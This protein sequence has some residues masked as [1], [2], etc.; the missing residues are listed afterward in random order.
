MVPP[1]DALELIKFQITM[2]QYQ[3]SIVSL[4]LLLLPVIGFSQSH[5]SKSN[6]S[7][8][9][10]NTSPSAASVISFHK[11]T[12]SFADIIVSSNRVDH[13]SAMA[14]SSLNKQQIEQ[15]NLGQD[16]PYLL[17]QQPSVVTTSD[18]GTGVGYTGIRIRGSDGTRVNVTING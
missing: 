13:R 7:I 6:D 12:T 14:Y 11:D 4:A 17:N 15:Q 9:K 1:L 18:A 10:V 5:S 2:F 16:L 3:K 8:P